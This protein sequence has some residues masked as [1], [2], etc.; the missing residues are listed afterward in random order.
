MEIRLMAMIKFGAGIEQFSGGDG[1]GIWFADQCR[2][3]LVSMP[4]RCNKE[5]T[6]SQLTIRNAFKLCVNTWQA[7]MKVPGFEF[8]ISWHIYATTYKFTNRKGEP[9]TLTGFNTFIKFNMPRAI[10]ILELLFWP[11]EYGLE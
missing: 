3:H 5:P 6:E 9:V 7:F 1:G 10:N 11:P 4:R 2:Q 8:G